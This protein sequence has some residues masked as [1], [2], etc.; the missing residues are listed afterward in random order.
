MRIVKISGMILGVIVVI[1]LVYHAFWDDH[2][3]ELRE[4]GFRYQYMEGSRSPGWDTVKFLFYSPENAGIGPIVAGYRL[5]VSCH[6]TDD[7]GVDEFIIQSQVFETYQCILKVDPDS[8]HY[9]IH[10]I[11]GLNVHYPEE[12]FYYN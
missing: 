9:H 7:D 6:D 10:Y 11:K 1:L 8:V 12:G 3:G 5:K 4:Y 2:C